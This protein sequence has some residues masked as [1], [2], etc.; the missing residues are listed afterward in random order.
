M[1]I[2]VIKEV[3]SM[4]VILQNLGTGLWLVEPNTWTNFLPAA[5]HFE[6]RQEA[7]EYARKLRAIRTLRPRFV[8]CGGGEI[9][10]AA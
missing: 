1:L 7:V 8:Y 4:K 3:G 2:L 10:E 9:F 6:T 5:R